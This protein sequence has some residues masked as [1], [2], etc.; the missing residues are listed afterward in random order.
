MKTWH[1]SIFSIYHNTNGAL[2]TPWMIVDVPQTSLTSLIFCFINPMRLV[3]VLTFLRI[4]LG[5]ISA[6][7]VQISINDFQIPTS[8]FTMTLPDS[9]YIS[10]LPRDVVRLSNVTRIYFI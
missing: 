5:I 7:G 2:L 9:Q 3:V 1:A 10:W 6:H 4:S 8:K